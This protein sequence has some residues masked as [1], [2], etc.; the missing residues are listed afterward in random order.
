MHVR[1]HRHYAADSLDNDTRSLTVE[2]AIAT[3]GAVVCWRGMIP[4]LDERLVQAARDFAATRYPRGWAGAAAMY[5]DSGALLTSVYVDAPNPGGCLCCET[6][7][8]CEAHKRGERV[9]ATVCVD[10]DQPD[11]D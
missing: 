4:I 1:K 2:C 5:T 10:L 11:G 8:I 7:A 6:G 9:V 3:R